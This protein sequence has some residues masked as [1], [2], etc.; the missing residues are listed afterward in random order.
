V[1]GV[2]PPDQPRPW[3]VLLLIAAG[4]DISREL[5]HRIAPVASL[6]SLDGTPV[7]WPDTHQLLIAR[8]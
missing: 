3:D 6:T 8:R 1:I 7:D 2:E 5:A 4:N